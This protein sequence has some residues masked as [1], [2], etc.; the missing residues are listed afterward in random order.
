[1]INDELFNN[2]F[3][4]VFK[5][6][7]NVSARMLSDNLFENVEAASNWNTQLTECKKINVSI[8]IIS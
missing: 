5:G 6:T 8:F 7:V 4:V 1:M 3:I 2:Y